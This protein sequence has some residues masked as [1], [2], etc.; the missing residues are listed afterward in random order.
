M[1]FIGLETEALT[2]SFSVTFGFTLFLGVDTG[3]P[4][5]DFLSIIFV[6]SELVV[7]ISGFTGVV[8][9]GSESIVLSER[10]ITLNGLGVV[11]E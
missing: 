3:E 4:D 7:F 1:V 11:V 8:F 9:F 5:A 10:F 2:F 6:A